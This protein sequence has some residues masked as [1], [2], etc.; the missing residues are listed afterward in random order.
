MSIWQSEVSQAKNTGMNANIPH[1]FH[2]SQSSILRFNRFYSV[3]LLTRERENYS[4]PVTY[5]RRLQFLDS[6]N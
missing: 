5:D 3:M 2:V 4:G 6:L 1:L